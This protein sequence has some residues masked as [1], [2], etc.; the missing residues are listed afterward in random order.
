MPR[1]PGEC[2]LQGKGPTPGMGDPP[3][4]MPSTSSSPESRVLRRW[5]AGIRGVLAGSSS[6]RCPGVRPPARSRHRIVC[7]PPIQACVPHACCLACLDL[8]NPGKRRRRLP[9]LF[10]LTY[11]RWCRAPCSL[12]RHPPPDRTTPQHPSRRPDPAAAWA[13]GV[14]P[15]ARQSTSL[16]GVAYSLTPS[17]AG[18]AHWC[19][20]SS[21]PQLRARPT[22]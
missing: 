2:L 6:D 5:R 11:L 8:A 19:C 16:C 3:L 12:L 9:C 1:L 10:D 15:L 7:I 4:M 20:P 13:S 17:R 22:P 18:L 14:S 21:C